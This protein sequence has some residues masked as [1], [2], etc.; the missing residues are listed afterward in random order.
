MRTT[1]VLLPVLTLAGAGCAYEGTVV[2]KEYQPL[3]FTYSL[4]LDATYRFQLRGP[5]GQVHSQLVNAITF[6]S[7]RVGDYFNDLHPRSLAGQAQ[8][9]STF[10]LMPEEMAEPKDPSR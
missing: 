7:Y 5:D 3:P 4:G 8:R 2:R 6:A 10:P 9:F 1:A